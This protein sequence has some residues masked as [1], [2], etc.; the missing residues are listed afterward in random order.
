M[1][2]V[3]IYATVRFNRGGLR[4]AAQEVR[5]SL[6]NEQT[7]AWF[8]SVEWGCEE[9]SLMRSARQGAGG[10]WS[11]SKN[12]ILLDKIVMVV[13]IMQSFLTRWSEVSLLQVAQLLHHHQN[14]LEGRGS[15]MEN[16][17]IGG[18]F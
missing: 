2:L 16:A 7:F 18:V 3:G 11:P 15:K 1:L 10:Q 12:N 17:A 13:L 14:P 4:Q 9:Q 5:T 6:C 8:Q